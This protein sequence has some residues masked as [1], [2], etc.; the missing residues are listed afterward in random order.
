MHISYIRL[1]AVRATNKIIIKWLNFRMF[2][3]GMTAPLCPF[4]GLRR[5]DFNFKL[6]QRSLILLPRT[7]QLNLFRS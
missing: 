2:I 1:W 3:Y 7:G 4:S 6:P 5:P